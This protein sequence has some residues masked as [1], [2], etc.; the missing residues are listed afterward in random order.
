MKTTSVEL[1]SPGIAQAPA[2]S[3]SRITGPLSY[4]IL[5]GGLATIVLA[6][7]MVV[8]SYSSL[9]YWDG[10]R[11]VDVAANG[12]SSV[13]PAWLWA[14]HNEH[15]L[16]LPKLFLAADLRFFRAHQVFLLASIFAIQLT[17]LALLSWSMRVLGGWTGDLW[18]SG[19]G[20][21]AFC[22]FCPSQNENFIWGFQVCFV[23][24]LL[25]QSLSFVALL[26]YATD[27]PR[28]RS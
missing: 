26:L 22:L 1:P 3:T 13:S 27:S 17:H 20:L 6:L 28:P 4:A 18:R 14:Q 16:V 7:Y 5:L 10:W 15:R 8:T 21:A 19:T 9:P 2:A 23:L 12:Y 24:P 11:Q 25:F